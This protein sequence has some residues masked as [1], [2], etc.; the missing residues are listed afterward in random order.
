MDRRG[1]FRS[2]ALEAQ[3]YGEI[4]EPR[5]GLPRWIY[6]VSLLL[7]ATMGLAVYLALTTPIML[8]SEG[9]ARDDDSPN[10]ADTCEVR[11]VYP[12]RDLLLSR[13]GD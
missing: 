1:I 13:R 8:R 12:V 9:C 6:A 2:A 7:L 3:A 10:H 4:G 5:I 11:A